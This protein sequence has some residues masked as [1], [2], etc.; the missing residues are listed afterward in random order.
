MLFKILKHSLCI[1]SILGISSIALA[2]DAFK[3]NNKTYTM[4]DIK[5]DHTA[6]L[7]EIKKQEYDFIDKIAQNQYLDAFF[8]ELATK[9]KKSVEQARMDYITKKT[10][11]SSKEEKELLKTLKD[12]PQFKSLSEKEQ[13][14]QI[15]SYLTMKQGRQILEDIVESAKKAKKIE[16]LIPKP[17]EPVYDMEITDTDMVRYSQELSSTKPVK[18]SSDCPITV[19]EYSEFQCPYCSRTLPVANQLM[20]EFKGKIRWIVRDFP[21]D[22][23]D[24]ARPA[25]IAAHCAAEQGKYWFMYK[26][27]FENQQKLQDA[28]IEKY[29]SSIKGLDIEKWKTCLNNPSIVSTIDKNV[30]SGMKIG[31]N[32]TPAFYINGKKLDTAMSFDTVKAKIKEELKAKK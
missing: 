18:C 6:E 32:G 28:D 8:Q 27:L 20:K 17:Q 14:E 22:F 12:H 11:I 2:Q 25:A 3:V 4:D 23:H 21:L 1:I 31:V 5:K 24:R 15:R 26:T 10:K 7:Y 19:V 29:A 16:I 9:Q 30:A 13:K